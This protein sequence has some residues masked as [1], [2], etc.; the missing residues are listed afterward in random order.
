MLATFIIG[1]REGLEAALIVGIIAAFLRRNGRDLRPMWIGVGLAVALSIAV[2]IGL[3]LVE[4]ALPQAAQEGMEAAIG[5]VAVVF[6]TGMIAWM[7]THARE[8][9]RQLEAETA[10]AL[11]EGGGWALAGMAFL[12]VL[13]EGFETSVF[14][15][16][17]FSVAQSAAWAAA[18][19]ALGLATA[20]V[21]GRGIYA[22]GVRLNLSRFFRATGLFL[23]LVA[24][25]LVVTSLRS[26][27][28]AGWLNVGQQPTIGLAWLVA[29]GTVRSA[30]LTGVLG[31]PADPRRIELLGWLAYLVP[32]ALFVYWPRSLRP[33]PRAVAWL[34]LAG[35]GGLAAA[36]LALALL[37]PAPVPRLPA[38][39]PL[40]AAGK[41]GAP[42]GTARLDM[43]TGGP[44]LTI[45]RPGAPAARLALAEGQRQAARHDGIDGTSWLL[46]RTAVPA[47][48]PA[49]LTLDQVIALAGGRV[50][51]GLNAQDNPG[52]FDASWKT[53]STT[54][55]WVAGG[56][57]LDAAQ[58]DLTIVTL[59]GGGLRTPRTLTLHGADGI[60]PAA[61]WR[62]APAYRADTAAALAS[63]AA[64]RAEHRF[65]GVLL[66][67]A[68]AL[69]AL[70]LAA[71]GARS[72][73]RPRA[74][75]PILAR[76]RRADAA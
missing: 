36:A 39:A 40:V 6:V 58:R 41:S 33:A 14:L 38:E 37:Y 57:L 76:T 9:K 51:V 54:S 3:D 22:G 47:G 19:A 48:V 15:L 69:P 71:T 50:P 63:L 73:L 8:L 56:V 60:A 59:S 11:G 16:A 5:A 74:A 34:R 75:A 53:Q 4:Q 26:A 64:A 28:E 55:V 21:V 12:A 43:T 42:A 46:S 52:P 17:T 68:L 62:V 49:M 67:G 70:L 44:V 35:A 25:G 7:K 32:V 29:P 1:L 65:W 23:I 61:G 24:A 45:S 2:G 27:H 20:V 31:I 10:A 18:G 30:L 13:R 72:L 66:P